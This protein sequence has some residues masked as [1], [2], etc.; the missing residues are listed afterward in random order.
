ME[1]FT[2]ILHKHLSGQEARG[3]RSKGKLKFSAEMREAFAKLCLQSVH[4]VPVEGHPDDDFVNYVIELEILPAST[5]CKE[6]I[7][8]YCDFNG[9][10]V[11]F[12]R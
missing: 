1:A 2:E 4:F 8:E 6:L 10:V 12:F 3:F 5:I 9:K 7:F 11:S